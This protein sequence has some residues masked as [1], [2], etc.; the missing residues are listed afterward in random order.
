[1]SMKTIVKVGISAISAAAVAGVGYLGKKA[2]DKKK[3]K[4]VKIETPDETTE[5]ETTDEMSEEK[6]VE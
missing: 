6:T 1:M 3:H 2:Y 4:V 5:S